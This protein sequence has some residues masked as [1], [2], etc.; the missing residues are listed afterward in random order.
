MSYTL[1][2]YTLYKTMQQSTH[3]FGWVGN[4]GIRLRNGTDLGFSLTLPR[5]NPVGPIRNPVFY[6]LTICSFNPYHP[7]S[8][9][10]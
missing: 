9:R 5:N 1:T 6:Q 4:A 10:R 3:F 2:G 8:G 7:I